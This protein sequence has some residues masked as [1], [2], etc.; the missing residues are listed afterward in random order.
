MFKYKIE[1]CIDCSFH[2]S[3]HG[4]VIWIDV[5]GH[6]NKLISLGLEFNIDN[7]FPQSILIDNDKQNCVV[8]FESPNAIE[9]LIKTTTRINEFK[10]KHIEIL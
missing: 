10:I 8:Y 1:G 9:K 4:Y 2:G 7:S 3:Y 6:N 5:N